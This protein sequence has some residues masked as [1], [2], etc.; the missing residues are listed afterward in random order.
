[1]WKARGKITPYLT[2]GA[3]SIACTCFYVYNCP[4]TGCGISIDRRLINTDMSP[5]SG[6]APNSLSAT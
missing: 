4:S 5:V 6:G 1:M 3:T 2:G